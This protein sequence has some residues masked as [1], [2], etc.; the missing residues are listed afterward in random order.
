MRCFHL[1]LLW[2]ILLLIVSVIIA[3]IIIISVIIIIVITIIIAIF[4]V[5][6][7]LVL[8][9]INFSTGS[10]SFFPVNWKVAQHRSW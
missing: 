4:N 3:I 2:L 5:C 1:L 8:K 10:D 9:G 7:L 6:L